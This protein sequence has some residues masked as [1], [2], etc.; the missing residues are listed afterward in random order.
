MSSNLRLMRSGG[1]AGKGLIVLRAGFLIALCTV[2][3]EGYRITGRDE[4]FGGSST[5]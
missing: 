3:A 4:D 1:F 5:R 2:I